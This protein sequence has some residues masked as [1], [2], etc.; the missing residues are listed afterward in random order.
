[1]G[2]GYFNYIWQIARNHAET[3]AIILILLPL[4]YIVNINNNINNFNNEKTILILIGISLALASI[5]RPNFFPTTS[6]LCFYTS[7][8][9]FINKHYL[10]SLLILLGYMIVLTCLAHNVYF[11]N[12]YTIFTGSEAHFVFN[13]LFYKN[14]TTLMIIQ[15]FYYLSSLCGIHYIIFTD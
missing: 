8:I 1:M 13:P 7:L 11:G 6:I 15:I 14:L 12:R 3:L 10:K 9:Y 4:T 5:S 2:F